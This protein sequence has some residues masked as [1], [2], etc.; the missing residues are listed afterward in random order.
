MCSI[1]KEGNSCCW[2]KGWHKTGKRHISNTQQPVKRRMQQHA[3]DVKCLAAT[4]K[5][6][7]SFADHFAQPIP[8]NTPKNEITKNINFSMKILWKENPLSCVKTFGSRQCELCSKERLGIL[9]MLRKNQEKQSTN[10]MRSTELVDT[11]QDFTGSIRMQPAL[12]SLVWTKEL[13]RHQH[14]TNEQTKQFND[15]LDLG[16]QSSSTMDIEEFPQ[17][18]L[19]PT[20]LV[21]SAKECLVW[22]FNCKLDWLRSKIRRALPKM[23][24]VSSKRLALWSQKDHKK[25]K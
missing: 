17:E 19:T 4:G 16:T 3:Q 2:V 20:P 8:K 25:P 23:V 15:H 21:I 12:M 13:W 11:N 6:S 10:A 14:K 22:K 9:K 7:N 18:S 24:L 1:A 5:L